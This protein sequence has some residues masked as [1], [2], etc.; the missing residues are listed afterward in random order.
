MAN[1]DTKMDQYVLNAQTWLN[2]TFRGK[3]GYEEVPENGKTGWPTIYGLIRAFQICLGISNPADSFGPGTESAFKKN[4][5]N[6]IEEQTD[7][8]SVPQHGFNNQLSDET[9]YNIYGIIQGALSCK[10]YSYGAA[11]KITCRFL[12]GVGNAIKKLKQDAGLS[13]TTSTITL[14]IMKALLSMDYFTSY[15]T[16]ERTTNIIN[17]QRYLNSKYESY[18]G[19]RP[20]DGVYGRRTNQAL[21]YAIQ[22][23]EG[24]ST[25]TANGNCG[26]ATKKSLP[27]IPYNGGYQMNGQTYGLS[28]QGSQYTD[29]K[30]T[31]FKKLISIALYFNGFGAGTISSN[32]DTNAIKEFQSTYAIPEIGT[33]DYTT[34]LSLLISCG[35]TDRSAIAC[36]C[37]TKITASNIEVLKNNGFK[38]I[39]RYLSNVEGSTLDKE[40]SMTEI[41]TIFS[42]GIRLFPIY[43]KSANYIDYFTASK[44]KTDGETA[45]N[46]IDKFY[47]QFGTIV[48][49][50]VDFDATDAQITNNILP[51]F[52]ALYESFMS[53]CGGAYRVGVYGTRNLCTRVCNAG[54]ACSSFVSDMSTGFSGNLG[55][56]IPD[57]WAFDQFAEVSISSNGKSIN[58]DK[59]GFSGKYKGISQQYSDVPFKVISSHSNSFILVNR[60]GSSIPVYEGKKHIDTSAGGRYA[61]DGNKIGEIK[62]NDFYIFIGVGT[63]MTDWIHPVMYND[64]LDV[65]VG[66][67]EGQP[68]ILSSDNHEEN[69]AQRLPNQELFSRVNY[70]PSNNTYILHAM[71]DKEYEE[72]H[73]MIFTINKSVPYFAGT[74]YKGMLHPGD[75]IKI[76]YNNQTNP[77]QSRPWTMFVDEVQIAGSS[78][79]FEAFNCFVSVGLEDAGSGSGR[80]WY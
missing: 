31:E 64:G 16:S 21:I 22:A 35:N 79:G 33:I 46:D 24:M 65:K 48:Y 74:T 19:I 49:F 54:Y 29:S 55:F 51:Y 4:F 77:G 62:V 59:D 67:I 25:S 76:N 47:L 50:G 75:K 6:G 17:M 72:A 38:Y 3:N 8:D 56:V 30:I 5:P 42:N 66:Y 20:C 41:K 13:D 32:L 27:N 34:W 26:P 15:D 61:V 57:N 80:A 1:K 70:D 45:V 53:K 14:N 60:G 73:P 39:G 52:K 28:Y 11:G 68:G 71:G 40:M 12:S 7:P 58:I 69:Y 10:G 78:V 2:D 43:Q 37:V 18:I 44:G 36:D 63:P 23:E 9:M